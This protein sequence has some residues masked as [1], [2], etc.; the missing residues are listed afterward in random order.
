[1]NENRT[2]SDIAGVAVNP[3]DRWK[4]VTGLA[5]RWHRDAYVLTVC[6]AASR[7]PSTGLATLD[8]GGS[9][10]RAFPD[11]P[12]SRGL[13]PVWLSLVSRIPF[14]TA[15]VVF[16][17]DRHRWLFGVRPPLR[18]LHEVPQGSQV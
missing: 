6:H 1:M 17:E 8:S 7:R 9:A 15:A 3:T 13:V 18:S 16:G 10:R 5:S 4:S 11:A 2:S 14:A 12:L